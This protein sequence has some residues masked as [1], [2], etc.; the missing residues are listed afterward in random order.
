MEKDF[1][2]RSLNFHRFLTIQPIDK[3]VGMSVMRA[4]KEERLWSNMSMPEF[5]KRVSS[6]DSFQRQV[7]PGTVGMVDANLASVPITLYPRVMAWL[8]AGEE[9]PE[10]RILS[11]RLVSKICECGNLQYLFRESADWEQIWKFAVRFCHHLRPD[12]AR[13]L[14]ERVSNA[15]VT[16]HTAAPMDS[17][18]QTHMLHFLCSVPVPF[19]KS[20]LSLMR[21]L[22]IALTNAMQE[23]SK[24]VSG[25][26]VFSLSPSNASADASAILSQILLFEKVVSR[27]Q[28]N[29]AVGFVSYSRALNRFIEANF[30]KLDQNSLIDFIVEHSQNWPGSLPS[31][32]SVLRQIVR[33]YKKI[34][35]GISIS[36]L[37]AAAFGGYRDRFSI[38]RIERAAGESLPEV[39]ASLEA[40]IRRPN[41]LSLLNHDRRMH[42]LSAIPERLRSHRT[43]RRLIHR[44]ASELNPGRVREYPEAAQ[45]C[46]KRECTICRSMNSRLELVR[47]FHS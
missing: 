13:C 18:L 40:L 2:K 6:T 24:S 9:Y 47:A 4:V 27:S 43:G 20:E 1:R 39:S 19:S 23:A 3:E 46:S 11:R 26:P 32:P 5:I 41:L 33:S 30:C 17:G 25:K 44:V 29:Y 31:A 10:S 14:R 12:S 16:F 28:P 15:Y 21:F 22:K 8:L 37:L 45:I 42:I 36:L 38:R 34:P 35:A 7:N